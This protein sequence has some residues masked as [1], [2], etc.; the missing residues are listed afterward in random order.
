MALYKAQGGNS[1]GLFK[2]GKISYSSLANE[3]R[4]ELGFRPKYI[5]LIA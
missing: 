3:Y 5:S 4:V 2:T 1:G